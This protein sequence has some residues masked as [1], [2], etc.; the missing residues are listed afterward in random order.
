MITEKQLRDWSVED[1]AVPY[2]LAPGHVLIELLVYEPQESILIGGFTGGKAKGSHKIYPYAK[3]LGHH[4]EDSIWGDDLNTD[5]LLCV[6]NSKLAHVTET[7]AYKL[8]AKDHKNERP[9]VVPPPVRYHGMIMDWQDRY[10]FPLNR[11]LDPTGPDLFRFCIPEG[12]ITSM[13]SLDDL[14]EYIGEASVFEPEE[15]IQLGTPLEE[16]HRMGVKNLPQA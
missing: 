7:E 9:Q 2:R 13:I 5:H 15:G 11:F 10:H 6:L 14:Y 3:I 8:W 4:C 12:L 1:I 16:L